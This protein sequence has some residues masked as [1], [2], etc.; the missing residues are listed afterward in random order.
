MS[1]ARNLQRPRVI[2]FNRAAQTLRVS[3]K[4]SHNEFYIRM[5][6]G[7]NV[8]DENAAANTVTIEQVLTWNP[9]VILLGNF[10]TAVP[11]DIY[12]DPRWQGVEAVKASPR[13]Q[14]AARWLPLGSAK[15]GIGADWIWLA[16]LLHPELAQVATCVRSC[17]IGSASS[18]STI[19]PTTK[20]TPCCSPRRI[21]SPPATIV[22]SRD[23]A[24]AH[25]PASRRS[26]RT[27]ITSG[28]WL[29]IALYVGLAS[30]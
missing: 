24:G 14:D 30:R 3:G 26:R 21:A 19:S 6:G 2:Y 17:A 13:L 1:G 16:G 15:P 10:D 7:L 4:K 9:Q 23:D 12:D 8:A 28:A 18:T 22:I 25:S 11:A 5:A 29:P 27:P 20:S